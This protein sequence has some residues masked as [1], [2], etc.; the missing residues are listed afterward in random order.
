M[1]T[2]LFFDHSEFDAG[3]ADEMERRVQAHQFDRSCR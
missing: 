2:W 1:L 3:D